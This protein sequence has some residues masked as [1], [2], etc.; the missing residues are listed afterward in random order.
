MGNQFVTF[1][2]EK[3]A[4][5]TFAKTSGTADRRVPGNDPTNTCCT[6]FGSSS[7]LVKKWRIAL[8]TFSTTRV[9]EINL[10][11]EINH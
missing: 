3:E 4:E 10:E 8:S 11:G 2:N 7:L 5:L 9:R 6:H 1:K